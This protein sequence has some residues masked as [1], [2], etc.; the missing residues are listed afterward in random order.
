M[1]KFLYKL[2]ILFIFMIQIS[3]LSFCDDI[4]DESIDVN[5]EIDTSAQSNEIPDVNSR[6]C[7]VLDRNSNTILYGK[8]EKNKVKMASTT[9]VMVTQTTLFKCRFFFTNFI[10]NT[11][12]FS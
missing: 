12:F 11:L 2:F 10:C 3:T 1:K 8:N 7:V 9:N 4:E 5:A 6:S